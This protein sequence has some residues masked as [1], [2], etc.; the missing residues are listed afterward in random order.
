M[1]ER[2]SRIVFAFILTRLDDLPEPA[3]DSRIARSTSIM[4][5]ASSLL[6][7]GADLE[8]GMTERATERLHCCRFLA[9]AKL[10][11]GVPFPSAGT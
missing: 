1:S 11:E 5:S 7:G 6:E 3:I 9:G 4:I 8:G 2:P 10:D